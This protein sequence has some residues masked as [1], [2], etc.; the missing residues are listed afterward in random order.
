MADRF[1]L[2]LWLKEDVEARMLERFR[3]LL[4]AFPSNSTFPF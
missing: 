4:E 1:Y 2:S 3:V